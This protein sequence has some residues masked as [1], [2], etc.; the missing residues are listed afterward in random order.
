LIVLRLPAFNS[1][2]GAITV[3]R[4][5]PD[6]LDTELSLDEVLAAEREQQN[7]LFALY[8][9]ACERGDY[10]AQRELH[11]ARTRKAWKVLRLEHAIK[12]G[13]TLAQAEKMEI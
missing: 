7:R 3:A 13:L 1:R 9:E 2:R 12:R 4:N 6:D 11:T 5:A 10:R 8:V